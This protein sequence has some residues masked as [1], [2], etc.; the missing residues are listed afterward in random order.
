MMNRF[1]SQILGT[2]LELEDV[3]I[4]DEVDALLEV[5][6]LEEVDT[7]KFRS[8]Q[9][10]LAQ[11]FINKTNYRQMMNRFLSQI[12]GANLELEDVEIL[13]EVDA[14]LE[15]DTLEEVDTLKFQA[16]NVD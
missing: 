10:R 13:D 1:L 8:Q 16:S 7:L 4:L 11:T 15:V 12:L 6:T 3:E 14:L 9:L 2:N 5:D